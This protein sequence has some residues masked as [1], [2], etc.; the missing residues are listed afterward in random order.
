VTLSI[1]VIA[2]TLGSSERCSITIG[3]VADQRGVPVLTI[4]LSQQTG[5][6]SKCMDKE[7]KYSKLWEFISIN[8]NLREPIYLPTSKMKI[9]RLIMTLAM[10]LVSSPLL[11]QEQSQ[12]ASQGSTIE[13]KISDAAPSLA[14]IIPFRTKLL[15]RLTAIENE[16]TGV[17]DVSEIEGQ[18]EDIER[19]L[20]G[21]VDKLKQLKDT[22]YE[23]Y[24][25]VMMLK[26]AF[27]SD[28]VLFEE[29]SSS[30]VREIN[31]LWDWRMELLENKNRL[32]EFQASF[33]ND[34]VFDQVKSSFKDLDRDIDRVLNLVLEKLE[35]ML[36]LQVKVAELQPE[37]IALSSQLKSVTSTEL[38][39]NPSI[40]SP[41][42][43][44]A[45]GSNLWNSF[46]EGIYDIR[47][48][49]SNFF[50]RFA[51]IIILQGFLSV[52]V[53]VAV[54]RNRQALVDSKLWG[55]LASRP[56]SAGSFL[57]ILAT[58]AFYKYRGVPATWGLAITILGGVTFAL[59]VKGLLESSWKRHFV[60]GLLTVLI[61]TTLML[62]VN[63]PL[64]LFRLYVFLT[65][66]V[67]VIFCLRWAAE[68]NRLEESRFYPWLLRLFSIILGVS[69]IAE[70]W[71]NVALAEYLFLSLIF[72]I[73]TILPIILFVYM[74]LG[75]LKWLF[76]SSYLGL[77][78]P[79]RA[80]A[81][82]LVRQIANII[83][84]AIGVIFIPN[85]FV[86]WGV[87]DSFDNALNSTLSFGFNLGSLQISVGLLI[88]VAAILYVSYLISFII[89]KMILN[90]IILTQKLETGVRIS[91]ARLVH[92]VIIFISF[93][94]ALA[95]L[96]VKLTE[97]TIM[98]GAL[99]VGIGF[100]L[101]GIVNNLLSGIILLFEQP[102]RVGDIIEI[103]G[104]WAE[105]KSIGLR[106]TTVKTYDGA[107]LMV[108]NSDLI[109]NQ[110][111]NWTLSNRLVRLIVPVGVAYG[112]DVP[113]VIDTL[114]KCAQANPLITKT[115]APEVLFMSFGESSL[116]FELRV[117][118]FD[119]GYRLRVKNELHQEIDQRFRELNIEIAF[120]Q[121][122]LH[123]RSMGES[124]V[125]Q[126]PEK[127]R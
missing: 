11:A 79:A 33:L 127:K 109:T 85:F 82:T 43:F 53:I 66:I 112:S 100:G 86:I 65:S 51:W 118:V 111:T 22:G 123:I 12:Q 107:D 2:T 94:L 71:G 15:T 36:R 62:T 113:L 3:G 16:L 8:F 103:G 63:L 70:I 75:G 76:Y 90:N 74:I 125:L 105:V 93:L 52:F 69:I 88:T 122:D 42:Y 14:D 124:I 89:Q 121:R 73:S 115:P 101:Q 114:E 41:R 47:W 19:K 116:D 96:G 32:K 110:V 68:S 56:F 120:P 13:N 99:G 5:E 77:L 26:K 30:L 39:S 106:A 37:I 20:G 84:V 54:Y 119:A 64:P 40:L 87:Y 23:N 83:Y 29:I 108:P 38:S 24:N 59:L 72:S 18:L 55:F 95:A 45:F 7:E 126:P 1:D 25:E 67:S 4:P 81:D 49:D 21:Y 98:L 17:K 91:L 27:R 117:W 78:T 10:F 60:Y 102:V 44:S 28:N 61:I 35:P 50:K 58:L 57:G 34:D 80:D 31:Q 104:L 6:K 46:L 92:Y 48:P 97:L 9:F